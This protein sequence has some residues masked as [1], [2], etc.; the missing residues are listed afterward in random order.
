M[1]P[2]EEVRQGRRRSEGDDKPAWIKL[3]Q[4][5]AEVTALDR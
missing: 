4:Q 3:N 1:R 2:D 5:F